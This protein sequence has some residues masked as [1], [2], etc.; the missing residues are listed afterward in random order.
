[1][2]RLTVYS[3]SEL[4]K[5][6]KL[7][8]DCLKVIVTICEKTDIEYFII[9]G[10]ALGAVRHGGFIPWDD[11]IDVGMTRENYEKFLK[12]APEL[13]PSNYHLQT[14]SDKESPYTYSKVRI[15]GTEFV[16][17]ANRH[18]DIHH[19][20]YVDIFPFDEVPSD[21]KENERQFRRTKKLV[22][23]FSL[24]QNHDVSK[25]PRTPKEKI[26]AGV[27]KVAHFAAT[28]LISRERVLRK[29]DK[30][31]TAYNDGK[32][33]AMACLFFPV[34]KTEYVRKED[35]YPLKRIAFEDLTVNLPKNDDT[36]LKTHYGNYLELPPPEKR[37]GHKPYSVFLGNEPPFIHF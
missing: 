2:D 11:D 24:R 36:Y 29:L 16:E 34:R 27:R 15:D 30:V 23:L 35:L 3:E 18:L 5:I 22:A 25:E 20:V 28:L 19:G 26:R 37:F 8:L 7:E 12:T 4:K 21:E 10:T 33:D 1:M 31:V 17:Y 13:L 6:Q 14:P 32:Q 9:G